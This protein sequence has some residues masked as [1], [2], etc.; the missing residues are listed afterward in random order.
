MNDGVPRA[1]RSGV[2][3]IDR[4]LGGLA[5]GDNV[6]WIA[7][8]DDRYERIEHAFLAE[9]AGRIQTIVVVTSRAERQRRLPDGVEVID[10]TASGRLARQGALSAELERRLID[11]RDCCVVIDGLA[12]LARRWGT[13]DALDFFTR[14]CPTML[15]TGAIT[16]W[17]TPRSLGTPMLDRIRQVTQCMF[18]LRGDQLHVTKAEGRPPHVQNSLHRLVDVD[19]AVLDL[20]AE[21]AGGR[22]ARGLRAIRK[23]LGL[24]QAQLADAAGVTPS[25]VSQAEAGSRGLSLDTLIILAD[26]LGVS[27]D[28]LVSAVPATGYELARHDRRQA[29]RAD[30]VVT[31]AGDASTGLRAYLVTLD[32]NGRGQPP[33]AHKGVELIAMLHGLVQVDVGDDTPVLRSGDSLLAASAAISGWRNL[34]PEPAAFYWVLRD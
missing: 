20:V 8:R 17:R 4:L 6:V 10:A 1:G 31:L 19:G 18:E 3:A 2:A 16:Y 25:A 14:T 21:P 29:V 33:T 23:D 15:Q 5:A 22:L 13:P 34:R 24:T 12:T 27:L 7:E 30:G 26:R 11:Y 9:S 28:R 32:A